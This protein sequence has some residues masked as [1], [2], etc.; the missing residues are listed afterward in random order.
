M[1]KENKPRLLRNPVSVYQKVFRKGKFQKKRRKTFSTKISSIE[2]HAA[3]AH[4]LQKH[5]QKSQ[6]FSALRK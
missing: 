1:R 2:E 6:V 5:L 4:T 3:S